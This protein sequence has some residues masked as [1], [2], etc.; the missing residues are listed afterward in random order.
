[1]NTRNAAPSADTAPSSRSVL[2][3]LIDRLRRPG[4]GSDPEREALMLPVMTRGMQAF[5]MIAFSTS[6]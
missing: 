6:T 2:R 5:S 1:M 4:A 3:R